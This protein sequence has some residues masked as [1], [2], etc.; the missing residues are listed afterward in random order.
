M[1]IT[2]RMSSTNRSSVPKRLLAWLAISGLLAAFGWGIAGRIDLPQVN[3]FFAVCSLLA[4]GA[5]LTIDADLASKRLQPGQTSEDPW[6][7]AAIRGLF[8][9]TFVV[10]LLDVGRLHASDSVPA[11]VRAGAL[12]ISGLSLGWSLWAVRSNR[13]FIPVIRIQSER[14][15]RVVSSGP[16]GWVRHP[17]YAGLVLGAPAFPL[18]LGSWLGLLPA[19]IVSF[20]FLRRT[21]HE[22]RFLRQHLDGYEEYAGRVRYRLIPGLW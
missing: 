21:A 20:L 9:A 2:L 19:A 8:L 14:G 4:L 10:S 7:L 18:A 16:Y 13:F 11:H 1:P 12:L 6:R 5:S 15:H 3:A 22:D 17:G